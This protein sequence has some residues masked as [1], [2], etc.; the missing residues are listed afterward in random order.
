MGDGG[1]DFG[2]CAGCG[3]VIAR[4]E[5]L[6][7][8][9]AEGELGRWSPRSPTDE[10]AGPQR[11][12]HAAC[13]VDLQEFDVEIVEL[14]AAID[15]PPTAGQTPNARQI[16]NRYTAPNADDARAHAL[17]DFRQI[18]G[19]DPVPPMAVR[20]TDAAKGDASVLWVDSETNPAPE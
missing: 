7:V 3:R 18:Y 14:R 8:E 5:H 6:W 10:L 1:P 11:T 12:W 16:I 9:D 20:V 13:L 17:E 15:A 19:G 2:V 4:P